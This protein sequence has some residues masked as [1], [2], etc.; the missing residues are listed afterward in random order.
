MFLDEVVLLGLSGIF[1][2]LD[3]L[4]VTATSVLAGEGVIWGRQSALLKVLIM[5]TSSNYR[6]EKEY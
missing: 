1:I 3:G 5:K 4:V 6:G 2:R